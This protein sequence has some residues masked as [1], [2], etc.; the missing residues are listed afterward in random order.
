M[1]LRSFFDGVE[2]EATADPR[3]SNVDFEATLTA[4][5]RLAA[6]ERIDDSVDVDLG[7]VEAGRIANEVE[8]GC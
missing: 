3:L 6:A 5:L 8:R 2:L 1:R 7:I 4:A